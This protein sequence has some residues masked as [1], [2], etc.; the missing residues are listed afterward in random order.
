[1]TSQAELDRFYIDAV[2]AKKPERLSVVLSEEEI[3]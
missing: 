3:D 1:M 2:R